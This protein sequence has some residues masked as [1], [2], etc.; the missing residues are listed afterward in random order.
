M[1]N[2]LCSVD[3]HCHIFNGRD[4]PIDAF[5]RKVVFADYPLAGA[6]LEPLI[7]LLSQIMQKSA[8]TFRAELKVLNHIAGGLATLNQFTRGVEQQRKIVAAALR[9]LLARER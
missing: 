6:L 9:K 5:L 1:S 3:V 8:P 4:L 7:F 2:S